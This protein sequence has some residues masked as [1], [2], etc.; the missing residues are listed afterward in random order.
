M[1]INFK[2]PDKVKKY[3]EDN[4]I[5]ISE[6]ERKAGD[7]VSNEDLLDENYNPREFDEVLVVVNG[8]QKDNDNKVYVSP[9]EIS[10]EKAICTVSSVGLLGEYSV[11]YLVF[12]VK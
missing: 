8:I 10:D 4:N 1:K 7:R 3:L 2:Y 6:I 12:K 11:N 5:D 9:K